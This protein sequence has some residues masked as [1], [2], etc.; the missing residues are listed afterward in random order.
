MEIHLVADT[1]L[2]FECNSLEVLPWSELGYDPIVVL[3]TKPVLDEID[4]HKKAPGRTRKRALEIFQ[5][6][7][8]MLTTS[9]DEVEI[10]AASP[11]V[12]LRRTPPITPAPTLKDQLDYGKTDDR[13]IGIVSTLSAQAAEYEV[14]LFTDDIGP[15]SNA[16]GL[17]VPF[18]MINESWRR[19]ASETTEEKKIRDLEKDLAT[20]REQEP[21]IVIGQCE[22]ANDAGEVAVVRKVA[23]PLTPSHLDVLADRLRGIHPMVTEFKVP[24]PSTATDD[25]GVTIVTDFSAPSED[26]IAAYASKY[27]QWLDECRGLLETLH[28]GR[29]EL[30]DDV[31]LTWSM[32]NKGNRPALQVRVVFETKGPLALRRLRRDQDDESKG[33]ALPTPPAKGRPRLP[34]PPKAPALQSKVTTSAPPSVDMPQRGLDLAGL[35]G[36]SA[37][38]RLLGLDSAA[39]RLASGL[40]RGLLGAA[41]EASR[42]VQASSALDPF[43]RLS[44]FDQINAGVVLREPDYLRNIHLPVL[45]PSHNPE[46]FYYDEWSTMVPVTEGAL[47]CDLWRH[48]SDDESFEFEVLFTKDGE[49]RGI[50]EC[51]VHAEN[52]TKPVRAK[53]VVMRRVE[54]VSMVALAKELVDELG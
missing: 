29:D 26:A 11:R 13:L 38:D 25:F 39:L 42:I 2:F 10:Q 49:A 53:V 43:G 44:Y 30:E 32:A 28:E 33:E 3:L 47:T 8:G 52:L 12:L 27:A 15:A 36:R 16:Q 5:R 6:V 35:T 21:L 40:D 31:S 41:A 54:H 14:R 23:I 1:N 19:P 24:P 9:V 17:G 48:Q 7:R 4:K 45:P 18:L 51:T 46:A 34:R 50:V 37:T 20:F 22:P